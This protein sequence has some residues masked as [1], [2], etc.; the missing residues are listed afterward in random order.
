LKE[1]SM[2]N[3]DVLTG[4]PREESQQVEDTTQ[5]GA[6]GGEGGEGHSETTS[7]DT[8]ERHVPL[9]AL[10]AERK[11]RQDWKEKAARYEGELAEV[12]R[13]LEQRQ[14]PQGEQV[15]RN[16]FEIMQERLI[17]ERF[18]TSEMIAR[19]AHTDIDEKVEV[20]KAAM[21]K[22]PA[23]YAQMQADKHP[24]EFAYREGA[25][26]LLAQEMGDDPTAYRTK[27]EAEIRQ[28]VMAELGQTTTN[29]AA[30]KTPL[31]TSLA[32]ARSSASRSS[33]AFTGPTPFDQV[34]NT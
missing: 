15:E 24:W 2:S 4:E 20:F 28:K 10:E 13:Q 5:Q 23:L 32:G 9:A 30:P 22:N 34:V 14:Q 19:A 21:E 26:M 27:L 7:Q 8:T 16:P 25:R 1:E 31:P 11:G 17:N 29:P 18:N 6:E 3:T 12:R 33:G